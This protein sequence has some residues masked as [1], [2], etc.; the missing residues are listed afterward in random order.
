MPTLLNC[1]SS[2]RIW[3]SGVELRGRLAAP[4]HLTR[5]IIRL[6]FLSEDYENGLEQ[7][8][9]LHNLREHVR[10]SENGRHGVK[11][12]M[13]PRLINLAPTV[14]CNSRSCKD[15][16]VPRGW[17]DGTCDKTYE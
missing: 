15:L 7:A 9:R 5:V 10:V 17:F 3:K 14:S 13:L 4:T 16:L 12:S 8:D 1:G 11:G 6:G 2:V